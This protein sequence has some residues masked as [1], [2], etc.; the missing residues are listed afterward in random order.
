MAQDVLLYA[1]ITL[2]TL[3]F[4]L[5]VFVL[6]RCRQASASIRDLKSAL[7]AELTPSSVAA[8]LAQMETDQASLFSTLEKLTTTVKRVSSRQGMRDLRERESAEPRPGA[9]KVEVLRHYGLAGKV[10]TDFYQRHLAI[11]RELS[12]DELPRRE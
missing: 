10:G 3:N 8:K 9:T 12:G 5:A 6:V 1:L 4:S 11:E 7:S 2:T